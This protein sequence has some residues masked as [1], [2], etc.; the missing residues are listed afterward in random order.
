MLFLLGM[1]NRTVQ[2]VTMDKDSDAMRNAEYGRNR[3]WVSASKLGCRKCPSAGGSMGKVFLDGIV[4]GMNQSETVD[5]V[6][7]K[8]RR[9][10]MINR[11]DIEG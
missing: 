9:Q 6:R 3:S 10:F 11:K 1:K 5:R 8:H 4:V 7:K 2:K